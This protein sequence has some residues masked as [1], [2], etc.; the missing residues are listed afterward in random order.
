MAYF[1]CGSGGSTVEI[2]GV[3]VDGDLK[4]ISTPMEVKLA[5]LPVTQTNDNR[6][7]TAFEY[8]GYLYTAS[9]THLYKFY[10]NKWVE[11]TALP[12]TNTMSGFFE[13]DDKLYMIGS[14]LREAQGK[15]YVYD[16][17]TW[18]DIGLNMGGYSANFNS[19][20][21]IL[22]LNGTLYM[23]GH[24][25]ET[26]MY[27]RMFSLQSDGTWKYLR[28]LPNIVG[29]NDGW[30]SATVHNGIMYLGGQTNNDIYTSSG[31]AWT[32]VTT[33]P[34]PTFNLV[35]YKDKL[36]VYGGTKYS[37][38]DNGSQ[39]Y[40]DYSQCQTVYSFDGSTWTQEK[41]VEHPLY[42]SVVINHKDKIYALGCNNVYY[43][44]S[45]SG[46]KVQFVHEKQFVQLNGNMIE[47]VTE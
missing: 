26:T 27:N 36:Y 34:K 30:A 13:Y 28:D 45:Y 19:R 37:T 46:Y 47:V 9:S 1:K 43:D 10:Q 33:A 21:K 14:L 18:T 2:D 41:D 20:G 12:Y 4:I 38:V 6:T 29:Y 39:D 40:K 25:V 24:V 31:A 7:V 32:K 42:Y 11:E 17:E 5:N 8:K 22:N 35:S 3:E 44:A 23:L 15:G 16:G